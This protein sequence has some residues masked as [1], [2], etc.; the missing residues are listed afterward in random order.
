MRTA[1]LIC[2]SIFTIASASYAIDD[3]K[4]GSDS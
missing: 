2:L 3:Y 4:P 1:F